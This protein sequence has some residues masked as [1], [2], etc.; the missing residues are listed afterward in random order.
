MG[1]NMNLNHMQ[2]E[3]LIEVSL[4][5]R[6][7]F[8]LPWSLEDFR[9]S[10]KDNNNIYLV[11]KDNEEVIGYCGMRGV[12][13]EGYISNVAVKKDYRRKSVA[14]NLLKELICQGREQNINYLTLEVRKSNL[15]AI[16]LYEK[17]GFQIVACRKNLYTMPYE[18]G[19]VMCRQEEQILPL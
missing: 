10:I 2:E 12:L 19:I 8:S 5:E 16:K 18:D 4:I 17:L 13:D 3:D 9:D 7:S 6:Q 11:A 14:Y 1:I 15:G